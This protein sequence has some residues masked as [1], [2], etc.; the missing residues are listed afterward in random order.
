M[1][2]SRA[3]HSEA[4]IAAIIDDPAVEALA[5]VEDG[6]DIGLL[7]LD[8]RKRGECEIAFL[9]LVAGQGGAAR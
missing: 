6:R 3:G 1:W 4:E 5:L 2:F 8:F 9:G 7:E